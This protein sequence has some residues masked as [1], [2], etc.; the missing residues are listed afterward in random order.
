MAKLVPS[1]SHVA[2][3]GAGAPGRAWV[4]RE[5]RLM[6]VESR[7][8][9]AGSVQRLVQA[10]T[11]YSRQPTDGNDQNG[12]SPD[13]GKH[14]FGWVGCA[15]HVPHE[16]DGHEQGVERE[17]ERDQQKN[18]PSQGSGHVMLPPQAL[19]QLDPA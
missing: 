19:L 16:V 10:G 8:S 18:F 15:P 17:H 12:Q 5:R 3:S 6:M 13:R 4:M 9:M 11:P 2:P 1:P 7:A 14:H